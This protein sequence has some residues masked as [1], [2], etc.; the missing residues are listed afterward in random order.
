MADLPPPS[1]AQNSNKT[2][3]I[4]ILIQF[5]AKQ[6]VA[7][8]TDVLRVGHTG[9]YGPNIFFLLLHRWF[10]IFDNADTPLSDTKSNDSAIGLVCSRE[11][12]PNMF[13]MNN[14]FGIGIDADLCLDFHLKREEAPQ[15]F[16]SRL[17]KKNGRKEGRSE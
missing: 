3:G 10:I 16:T 13:V 8:C 4:P 6:P 15:K 11:D 5:E 17:V 1:T 12:E 14:Y 9:I 7:P 2:I